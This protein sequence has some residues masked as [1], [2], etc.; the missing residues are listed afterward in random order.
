MYIYTYIPTHSAR[1]ALEKMLVI[2]RDGKSDALHPHHKNGVHHKSGS[3]RLCAGARLRGRTIGPIAQASL[4]QHHG[5]E[6]VNLLSGA[7]AEGGTLV[8]ARDGDVENG[9]AR[10]SL[11]GLATGL[12][13]QKCKRRRLEGKANLGGR[14]LGGGV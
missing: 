12:L 1:H 9:G 14:A 13:D 10:D 5:V 4:A 6:A 8:D 11:R 3:A 2:P 7:D